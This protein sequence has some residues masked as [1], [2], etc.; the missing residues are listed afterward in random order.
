MAQKPDRHYFAAR[1]A[2]EQ[3][4]AK[5]AASPEARLIHRQMV[6]RYVAIVAEMDEMIEELT[7]MPCQHTH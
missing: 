1:A 5:A 3:V 6:D 7:G 4:A 2:E